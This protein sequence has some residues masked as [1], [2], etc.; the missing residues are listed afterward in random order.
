MPPIGSP[1]FWSWVFSNPANVLWL[2]EWGVGLIAGIVGPAA[3]YLIKEDL[4]SVMTGLNNGAQSFQLAG[5][6]KS[7]VVAMTQGNLAAVGSDLYSL[8]LDYVSAASSTSDV[9]KLLIGLAVGAQFTEDA[10]TAGAVAEIQI[11]ATLAFSGVQ[12]ASQVYIWEQQYD[13]QTTPS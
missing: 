2:V 6:I 7:L 3:A 8:A 4:E 1:Q 10:A 12:L 5:D 11:M 13:Q 9:A